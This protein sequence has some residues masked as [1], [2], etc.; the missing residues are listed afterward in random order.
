MPSPA[1]LEPTPFA[2]RLKVLAAAALF[3]SGGAAIKAVRL[4]G[5]QVASFRSALAALALLVLVREVRRRPS[6]R[7]LSVGLAYAG[8]MILFVLSTKLTTAAAAIYLQS[9]APLYV[10]L[11]SPWL[12]KESIRARDLVYMAALALGLSLFFVGV[13]PVS[14]TAPNP[15]LGNLLALASGLTWA[16]T[17]MGLRD[18]GRQAGEEGGS[19]APASAFWGNVFAALACLPLALP[20]V[21]SRPMDWAILGYL[22]L[23]QIAVAYLVLL[24][25]LEKVRAFEASLLLLLEPV[26]N[27]IWAWLVHGERPGAGSLAGGGVI[28]LATLVKSWVDGREGRGGIRPEPMPD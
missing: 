14:A 17:V 1:A 7:V 21:A 20:V 11:L 24:R 13:D 3:S 19:W 16:L 25:G 9:T 26:L 18:L 4:T 2:S 28:I 27:P 10:L 15:P 12:L 22:G 6:L 5:W 8:T 23:F